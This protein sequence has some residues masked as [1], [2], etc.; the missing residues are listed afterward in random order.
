V[1]SARSEIING[2]GGGSGSGVGGLGLGLILAM[3]VPNLYSAPLPSKFTIATFTADGKIEHTTKWIRSG[4]A[5][6]TAAAVLLAVG[7]SLATNSG[8]PFILVMAMAAWKVWSYE[9]ALRRGA[10]DGPRIDMAAQGSRP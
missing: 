1:A 10:A 4:E 6:A 2:L 7:G 3:Q 8:W 9:D 5:E